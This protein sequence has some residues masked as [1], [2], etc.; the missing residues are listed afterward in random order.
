MARDPY[1]LRVFAFADQLVLDVYHVSAPFP[2]VER[3]GL[4][5]QLRR[6]AISAVT[7]IVEGSARRTSREHL[8]FFSIALGPAFESRYLLDV[9]HRLQLLDA[10]ASQELTSRYTVLAKSLLRLMQVLER[11]V[12]PTRRRSGAD[13][14]RERPWTS[15]ADE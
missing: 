9:A 11:E 2:A 13:T 10:S 7:N 8:S 14:D 1:K 4:Q 12:A 3:Y 6:A 5:A 15:G